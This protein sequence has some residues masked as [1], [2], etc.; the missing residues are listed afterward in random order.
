MARRASFQPQTDPKAPPRGCASSGCEKHG[1]FRAPKDR[2]LRE[3]LWFCLEH[4]R[5]YNSGWDFYRG[6]GEAAI[7]TAIRSDTG[8]QRPT[9]PLGSLGGSARIDPDLMADPLGILRDTALHEK[10]RAPPRH[11]APPELRAALGLLELEWPLDPATLKSRYKELAKRYHPD[12]NGGD[13]ST[14]ERL[15]DINRAYSLLRQR[16]GRAEPAQPMHAG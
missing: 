16:V 15:K 12:A 13:R 7:E 3:Y 14:E 5:Q 6:M 4:V 1:E 8:W 11:E 10:R 2:A 9:W